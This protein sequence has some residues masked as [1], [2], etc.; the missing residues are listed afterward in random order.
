MCTSG[1]A[2]EE[3]QLDVWCRSSPWLAS[4]S[5]G[6]VQ[7]TYP[8]CSFAWTSTS[9]K[10]Q[11]RSSGGAPS[12]RNSQQTKAAPARG[13]GSGS[14]SSGGRRHRMRSASNALVS[15]DAASKART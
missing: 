10:R 6:G 5:V 12:G 7:V 4:A 14:V 8:A 11:R 15:A 9:S 13:G 3:A 1:R 2:A